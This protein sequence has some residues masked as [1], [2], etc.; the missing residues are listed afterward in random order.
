MRTR[1]EDAREMSRPGGPDAWR[2]PVRGI[3]WYIVQPTCCELDREP[4]VGRKL[5]SRDHVSPARFKAGV[6]HHTES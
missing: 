4:W 5:V 1:M 2:V 6:L 3:P